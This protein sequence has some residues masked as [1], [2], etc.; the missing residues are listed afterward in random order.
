MPE[1]TTDTDILENPYSWQDWTNQYAGIPEGYR[2]IMSEM[3]NI[4]RHQFLMPYWNIYVTDDEHYNPKHFNIN[5]DLIEQDVS[6]RVRDVSITED[7]EDKSTFTITLSDYRIRPDADSP[8]AIESNKYRFTDDVLFRVGTFVSIELGYIFGLPEGTKP[9]PMPAFMHMAGRGIFGRPIVFKWIVTE[10]APEYS[11]TGEVDVK[12]SGEPATE[13]A[14]GSLQIPGYQVLNLTEFLRNVATKFD[15][16]TK[17]DSYYGYDGQTVGDAPSSGPNAMNLESTILDDPRSPVAVNKQPITQGT[18]TYL[19][20]VNKIKRYSNHKLYIDGRTGIFWD[21]PMQ[22][23]QLPHIYI[24][25]GDSFV[26][27]MTVQSYIGLIAAKF[28]AYKVGAISDILSASVTDATFDFPRKAEVGPERGAVV[29][30]DKANYHLPKGNDPEHPEYVIE[31]EKGLGAA[32]WVSE[33]FAAA[34]GPK[35]YATVRIM[36]YLIERSISASASIEA[37]TQEENHLSDNVEE[38]GSSDIPLNYIKLVESYT[39]HTQWSI[40]L[41]IEVIGDPAIRPGMV[42]WIF[43]LGQR[44]TGLY[45]IRRVEHSSG[46]NGFMQTLT[47]VTNSITEGGSVDDGDTSEYDGSSGGGGGGW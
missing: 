8:H 28:S 15:I 35:V 14:L 39:D 32:G 30:E 43:G 10:V 26:N 5:T 2:S 36:R 6:R 16:P 7:M 21:Q 40:E 17:Y 25:Q 45:E 29:E 23:N 31:N 33:A 18:E 27:L 3:F 47:C 11:N 4:S 37:E 42:I 34:S 22:V 9:G 44:F 1:N 24:H 19:E 20:L 13:L 46:T 12:I 41:S 38:A